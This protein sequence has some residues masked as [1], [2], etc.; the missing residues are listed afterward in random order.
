[1]SK[2]MHDAFLASAWDTEEL[3]IFR[4][5]VYNSFKNGDNER[6]YVAECSDKEN[7]PTRGKD[8]L[9]IVDACLEAIEHS[10][11]FILLDVGS[12]GT[13]LGVGNAVAVSSFLELELFQAILHRKPIYFIAVGSDETKLSALVSRFPDTQL[14][15]SRVASLEEGF[16][17]ISR[18]MDGKADIIF[19][20][21]LIQSFTGETALQRQKN[22]ADNKLFSEPEMFDGTIVGK[23]DGAA[24]DAE[25]V[26]YYLMLGEGETHTNRV[27]TRTWIAI[28]SLMRFHYTSTN[29]PVVISLWRRAF[30]LWRRATSWRGLHGH[31]WLGNVSALGSH[32]HMLGRNDLP[33][34]DE[35]PTQFSDLYS[36][37]CSAYYNVSKL[38][39][40]RL[41]GVMLTRSEAYLSAGLRSRPVERS[42]TLLPLKGALEMRR[43]RFRKAGSTFS[44][45]LS[46][47]EEQGASVNEIGFL[48]TE[49]G[50]VEALA[51]SPRLGR[52][53][54]SEGLSLVDRE[55]WNPGFLA[56]AERKLAVTSLICLDPTAA[57]DAVTRALDVA[58]ENDMLDQIRAP[59]RWLAR[60]KQ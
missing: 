56:R 14:S 43:W 16:D 5:S 45:A 17:E 12:Y 8:Q 35:S 19:N 60:S 10:T 30:A 40:R 22:W 44:Q 6:I 47:A 51:G 59:M 33:F 11:R 58:E 4:E 41:S 25:L 48:M 52:R 20:R 34:F 2:K 55:T 29:D 26:D 15:L 28:R 37:L 53:R 42:S 54:I 36:D 21:R 3:K 23:L 57:R 18:I 24:F 50:F 46:I 38:V 1:M 27:L 32:A 9:E 39:G 13:H 7:S 49:L 31:I